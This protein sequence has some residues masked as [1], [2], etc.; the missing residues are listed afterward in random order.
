MSDKRRCGTE[1][2]LSYDEAAQKAGVDRDS[3]DYVWGFNDGIA[4]ALEILRELG[5]A[6]AADEL[7]DH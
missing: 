5:H 2:G 6:Q 4:T 3:K 7:E 1:D